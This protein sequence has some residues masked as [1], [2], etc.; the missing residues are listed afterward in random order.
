MLSAYLTPITGAI[1][2]LG[3]IGFLTAIPWLIHNYRKYGFLS[4]WQTLV[5]FSF[6]FYALSAYFLVILPLPEVQD[7]CAMLGTDVRYLQLVPFY[8]LYEIILESPF[9]FTQPSSY[10]YLI[11]HPSFLPAFF[12]GLILFPLGVYMRYL[13]GQTLTIQKMLLLGFF[14]SLFFEITQLTGLYGI[15]N[16]PYRTFNVDDLILNTLGA[17]LGFVIAP[18]FLALFP[19]E[20]KLLE[21]S[22][23][24]FKSGNVRPL[25]Q[26]LAIF[27]DYIIVYMAWFFLSKV[28]Y[29]N[30]PIIRLIFLTV[31]LFVVQYLIPLWL[32]GK[33]LGTIC[34]KFS[35]VRENPAKPWPQALMKRWFAIML[36]WFLYQLTKLVLQHAVLDID[37]PYYTFWILLDVG[38]FLFM[39]LIGFLLFFHSISVMMKKGQRRFYFDK[40]SGI[41]STYRRNDSKRA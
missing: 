30:D 32:K 1:I 41:I 27:V 20:E 9:V 18:I 22:K 12:N 29:M 39:L 31:G 35:L 38:L 23:Q 16:C 34:L 17:G 11:K 7:T 15:Y 33:T 8:F 25:P 36:P 14:V 2:V 40:L 24:I 10:I 13:R 6:V 5:I 26:L 4:F 21:K 37:S 28:F 3:F 19:A